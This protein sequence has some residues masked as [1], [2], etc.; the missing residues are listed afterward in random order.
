MLR[1]GYLVVG[2]IMSEFREMVLAIVKPPWQEK[3]KEWGTTVKG[4]ER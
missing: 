4:G 1:E 2:R 3:F